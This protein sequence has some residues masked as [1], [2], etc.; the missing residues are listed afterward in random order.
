[1]KQTALVSK[2][3]LPAVSQGFT[4]IELLIVI[5]LLGALAVGLLAI[6][7]NVG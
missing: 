1:M 4:L 5:A 3:S 2:K 7:T 6:A